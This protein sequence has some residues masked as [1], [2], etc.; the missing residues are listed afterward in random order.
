MKRGAEIDTAAPAALETLQFSKVRS[1]ALAG[2]DPTE[3]PEFFAPSNRQFRNFSVPVAKSLSLPV[4]PD[5]NRPVRL[6]T[7]R[8]FSKTSETGGDFDAQSPGR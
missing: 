4:P 8:Q 2:V 3:M 5:T 7:V 6:P 1:K